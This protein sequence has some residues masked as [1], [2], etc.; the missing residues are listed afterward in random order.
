MLLVNIY[1]LY[2]ISKLFEDDRLIRI[3]IK[4]MMTLHYSDNDDTIYLV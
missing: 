2:I 1:V 3:N 4:P